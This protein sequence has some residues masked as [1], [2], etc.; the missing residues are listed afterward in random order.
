MPVILQTSSTIS[1][2]GA[3]VPVAQ[4]GD[5]SGFAFIKEQYAPIAED[6]VA[7]V[8]KVE[9]RYTPANITT[10]TTTTVKSG[11]GFLHCFTINNPAAITVTGL[12]MTVYDNTAASGT[13]IGTYFIP[14]ST[15]QAP[16]N[17]FLDDTFATG[18]TV[19]TSGP[20]VPADITISYR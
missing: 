13:K 12:T 8:I 14:L 20:T 6:N 17:M 16:I 5:S 10:N 18:L 19:V 2:G 9:E 15:T 7:G 1:P 11:S 3:P 4:T